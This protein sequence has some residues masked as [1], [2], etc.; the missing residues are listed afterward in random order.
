MSYQPRRLVECDHYQAGRGGPRLNNT[1]FLHISG[2]V[3]RLTKT[4]GQ[5]ETHRLYLHP[6][7]ILVPKI[8]QKLADQALREDVDIHFKFWDP[9]QLK[10][11]PLLG[12][13]EYSD[14]KLEV[15]RLDRMVVLVQEAQLDTTMG[16]IDEIRAC[17][18]AGF[19]G[20]ELPPLTFPIRDGVGFAEEPAAYEKNM[21]RSFHGLR[22][23]FVARV[24]DRLIAEF[25]EG[26]RFT[27][28]LLLRAREIIAE[29]APLH[30]IDPKNLALNLRQ[31]TR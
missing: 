13:D 19:S 4:E 22:G 2:P 30:N 27:P 21:V 23:N 31:G 8:A 16:I 24:A 20:R 3:M 7:W 6:P 5:P 14:V 26:A 10:Q 15:S 29:L 25:G 9:S 18:P 1:D 12:I 28:E 17:Y 11:F